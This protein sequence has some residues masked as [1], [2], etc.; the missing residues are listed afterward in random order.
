MKQAAESQEALY[1]EAM[2]LVRGLG[3]MKLAREVGRAW[4]VGSVPLKLIVKPDID[5]HV[6]VARGLRNR[7]SPE[8]GESGGRPPHSLDSP[9]S[10]FSAISAPRGGRQ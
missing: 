7:E 10:R 4:V 6:L 5:V 3:V 8:S 9:D 2:G 1:R